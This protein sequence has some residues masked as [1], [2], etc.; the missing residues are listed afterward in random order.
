MKPILR[1]QERKD[2]LPPSLQSAKAKE[3]GTIDRMEKDF[4][5]YLIMIPLL[6]LSTWLENNFYGPK[7]G[8]ISKH[9][10]TR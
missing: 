6:F 3:G 8:Q 1:K 9:S 7:K 4:T 5:T 2:L 10:Q